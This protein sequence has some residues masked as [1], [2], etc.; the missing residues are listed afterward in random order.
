LAHHTGEPAISEQPNI[1]QRDRQPQLPPHEQHQRGR[2]DNARRDDVDTQAVGRPF[3]DG[4]DDTEHAQH[5]QPDTR[6]IPRS[7][8]RISMLGQQHDAA[9]EQDN[10]DGHVDQEHRA[11][12]EVLEEEA[13]EHGTE[14]GARR[15]R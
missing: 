4:V 5:R 6:Q 10:H 1:D 2:S 9:D 8:L 14:R 3:L 15:E 13:T 11:P 12:P 7:R